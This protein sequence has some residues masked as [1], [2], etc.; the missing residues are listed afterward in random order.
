MFRG[1][2]T[3]RLVDICYQ[4]FAITNNAEANNL[5]DVLFVYDE[6]YSSVGLIHGGRTARSEPL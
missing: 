2:T 5:A 1:L 3:S 4:S 6:V